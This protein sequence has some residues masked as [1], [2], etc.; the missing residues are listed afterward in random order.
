M[1]HCFQVLT[2]AP[3]IGYRQQALMVNAASALHNFL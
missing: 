2:T 3:E 1:K